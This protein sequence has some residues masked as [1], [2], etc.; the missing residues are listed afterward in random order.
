MFKSKKKT[1]LQLVQERA[2]K[3]VSITNQKI[4]KLGEQTQQLY[5]QLT[6]IQELF[7]AIRN[8][9]DDKQLQYD[10][11]K[12]IRL[13]WKEQAD[14]IEHD[15]KIA[16][17][18][19]AGGGAAGVG[20]GVAVAALGPTAAMGIATTFGVASTGT[21]ISTLSGAA[22]TNAALAW[23]GGGAL[24]V[25]G[26]GMAAG[27]SLLALAGPVG[28]AIAG[29]AILSSGIALWKAKQDKKKLEDLFCL[30]SHRDEV[31]Y[32]L[33][34]VELDERIAH[35]QNECP[36]L[37]DAIENV[38]SFGTDYQKMSEEQQYKLGAYLNMMNSSTQ[39]L[40]NPIL[41]L[42]PAFTEDKLQQYIDKAKKDSTI[43]E[44]DIEYLDNHKELIVLL[45]NLTFNVEMDETD[46]KLLEKSLKGNK[47]FL[48]S[49]NIKKRDFDSK[50][51]MDNVMKIRSATPSL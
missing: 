31:K 27:E 32:N 6:T 22:A 19:A 41:G 45:V 49:I 15:H 7:D 51:I 42:Q 11:I 33:A 9:P 47:D 36:I 13:N 17:G 8:I 48:K 35:I 5:I 21:A 1:T 18:K 20:A 29:V 46:Q 34:S 44:S 38:K 23:L 28:W 4:E 24:A 37:A 10:E 26:G 2:E 16:Q 14:K 30:I 25:N 40:V 12:K 43:T 39:L 3:A 50:L